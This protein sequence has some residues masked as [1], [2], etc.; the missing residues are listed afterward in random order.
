MALKI[1]TLPERTEDEEQEFLFSWAAL[2]EG[3]YP[4]LA[5]M[6]AVPNGAYRPIQTGRRLKATGVKAGVPDVC[7][8][9]PRCGFHGMYIEMKRAKGGNT[10]VYQRKWIIELYRQGYY[11]VVAHGADDA[12]KIIT[13]YM[14]GS[15]GQNN[16]K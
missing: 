9:V 15:L 8:P 11:A 13:A 5:L 12:I 1:P 14:D 16:S 7:L 10:S 4:E 6:Y 3:K 2:Q